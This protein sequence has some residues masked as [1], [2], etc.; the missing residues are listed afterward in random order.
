MNKTSVI[1]IILTTVINANPTICQKLSYGSPDGRLEMIK[2]WKM[3]EMLEL[4]E[5]QASR[6]FPRYS[7][8]EKELRNI[9]GQQRELLIE[10]KKMTG[11]KNGITVKELENI[12][13]KIT[14]LEKDKTEKK[15]EFFE[16]LDQVLST[17]QRA[18]YYGFEIWFKKELRQGL[19]K[20]GGIGNYGKFEGRDKEMRDK[21]KM[22]NQR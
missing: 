22:K 10:M 5:E 16:G 18:K 21:K 7:S 9:S 8:L 15:Q 13:T 17:D 1:L 14:N 19:K 12:T 4:S 3:T 11:E 20:R 2:M 6:F